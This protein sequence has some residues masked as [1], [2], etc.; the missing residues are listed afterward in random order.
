VVV[1][2]GFIVGNCVPSFDFIACRKYKIIMIYITQTAAL[3]LRSLLKEKEA[4]PNQGLR[5]AVERGGCAG[6]Q[7]QME[8]G[9]RGEADDVFG[10]PGACVVVDAESLTFL[11]ES[12]LDYVDELTGSG[13]KIVNPRATRSCGCG[14]SFEPQDQ[15]TTH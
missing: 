13:F 8:L 6:M 2:S 9:T 4:G 5:L 11:D 14:T 15:P 12:T 7:Y 3:Q 1:G 10:D